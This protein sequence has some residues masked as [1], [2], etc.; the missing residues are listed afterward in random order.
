MRFLKKF[1]PTLIVLLVLAFFIFLGFKTA[2]KDETFNWNSLI[3]GAT[4]IGIGV[5]AYY[6]RKALETA[7]KQHQEKINYDIKITLFE[8]RF[9]FINALLK[10]ND[11]NRETLLNKTIKLIY[12]TPIVKIDEKEYYFIREP[13]VLTQF[14]GNREDFLDLDINLL[15]QHLKEVEGGNSIFFDFRIN[16]KRI[17]REA[18]DL[19]FKSKLL[20]QTESI[21][22]EMTIF[23]KHLQDLLNILQPYSCKRQDMI[24]DCR[25]LLQN[26]KDEKSEG[27]GFSTF[28]EKKLQPPI[29]K[30]IEIASEEM[31]LN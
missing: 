14:G 7:N 24:K 2:P 23:I 9:E 21:A 20:F 27:G 26:Y 18:I 31:K 30:I 28:L 25:I 8:K 11:F 13:N 15:L 5:A 17:I 3:A 4:I 10:T 29:M 19:L 22:A 1:F 12:D 6:N 16:L